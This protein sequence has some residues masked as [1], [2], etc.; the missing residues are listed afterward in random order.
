MALKEPADVES[1][2]F[3]LTTVTVNRDVVIKQVEVDRV[4]PVQFEGDM[5][6]E[7]H[8]IMKWKDPKVASMGGAEENTE[9]AWEI[10]KPVPPQQMSFDDIGRMYR[11]SDGDMKSFFQEGF[12]GQI[13]KAFAPPLQPRCFLYRKQAHLMNK[14]LEK[15]GSWEQKGDVLSELRDNKAGFIFDGPH[16]CGKSALLNQVVHFSRSREYLTFYIPDAAE[17][18]S[19]GFVVPSTTLPG[20]FDNP[21]EMLQILKYFCRVPVNR[22]ILQNRKLSRKYSI[23]K[24]GGH[25]DL[26][27]VWDLLHYAFDDIETTP[28]V[29]KYFLDEL[30]AIKDIPVIFIID[31]FDAL[32]KNTEYYEMHE[33]IL[34]EMPQ[35]SFDSKVLP[36]TRIHASRL[37]LTRALNFI[38]MA[39]E[40]NK[41]V[42]AA[43][44]RQVSG[45]RPQS[46]HDFAPFDPAEDT[47]LH[48]ME[49]PHAYD[50]YEART[51]LR[52]YLELMEGVDADG[53]PLDG[54]WSFRRLEMSSFER[55][56]YKIKFI[57]NNNPYLV[58]QQSEM[59]QYWG[60]EYER[61][62]QMLARKKA[63]VLH[64]MESVTPRRSAA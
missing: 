15:M 18:T 31:S 19:G 38:M 21:N 43:T 41:L 59:K 23:P 17:W 10:P 6:R 56:L 26:D 28:V 34:R 27:T 20:F 42:V 9:P 48:P 3:M 45:D 4:S 61:Q 54:G 5:K 64:S 57:T 40:P 16:G 29:F 35:D 36:K 39:N 25:S 55:M 33:D 62:R 63:A 58:W 32:C 44:C 1:P 24:Q 30:I 50:D 51:I 49:M 52:C 60:S 47:L 22:K 46:E 13:V 37:T 2:R 11:L 14:Y 53:T 7:L 12:A 8:D